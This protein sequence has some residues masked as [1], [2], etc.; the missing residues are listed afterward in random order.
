MAFANSGPCKAAPATTAHGKHGPAAPD[1]GHRR[2]DGR[3]TTHPA[4]AHNQRAVPGGGNSAGSRSGRN[5]QSAPPVMQN[6]GVPS[7]GHDSGPGTAAPT[8]NPSHVGRSGNMAP[9]SAQG[10]GATPGV[11]ARGASVDRGRQANSLPAQGWKGS[12]APRGGHSPGMHGRGRQKPV[13]GPSPAS[14]EYAPA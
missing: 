6:Q 10:V 12:G 9:Q 11:P 13:A 5:V 1:T 3:N 4:P 8:W 2:N 7:N 14:K